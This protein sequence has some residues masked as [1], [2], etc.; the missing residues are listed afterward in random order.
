MIW[1]ILCLNA[2]DPPNCCVI[3]YMKIWNWETSIMKILF[4]QCHVMKIVC[5]TYVVT[6]TD[7][8]HGLI[9]RRTHCDVASLFRTARYHQVLGMPNSVRLWHEDADTS[10]DTVAFTTDTNTDTSAI[11]L[12]LSLWNHFFQKIVFFCLNKNLSAV[13]VG[14][15]KLDLV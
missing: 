1:N 7:H 12:T 13:S 3:K 14:S 4:D 5:K 15:R 11:I 6:W 10:Q 8:G 2:G 9:C